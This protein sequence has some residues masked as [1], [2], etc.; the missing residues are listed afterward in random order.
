MYKINALG[1]M[2]EVNKKYI[3]HILHF[4]WCFYVNSSTWG[5]YKSLV[6]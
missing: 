1:Q 2:I 5:K 6:I 3:T 4:H